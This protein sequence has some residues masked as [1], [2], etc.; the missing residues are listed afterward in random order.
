MKVTILQPKTTVSAKKRVCAYARVSTD[1]AKQGESLENQISYYEKLLKSH[2]DYEFVGVFGD[3]GYTGTK[4]NRPGFQKMIALCRAGKIDIILTKSI[5]RFARNT[6]IVL[7]YVRELKLL[8]VEVQFEKENLKTLS[9]DGELMLT[10]LSSFAEE[11]SRSISENLKWRIKKKFEK[12]EMIIN[13]NR[14]LGYDKDEYGDLII[15]K[16]EGKIIRRIFEDYLRGEGSSK[17]AKALNKEGIPA[18]A[19]GK[20]H[21]T[22]VLHILKNEKY[23]GDALLQKYFRQDHLCKRNTRNNGQRDS[24]YIEENHTPIVSKEMWKQVQE[25]IKHRCKNKKGNGSKHVLSGMLICSKCGAN[26]NRRVWNS[27]RPCQKVI[28]QCG[29][30]VKKGKDI[31]SGTSIAESVLEGLDI[32]EETIVK[33]WMVNGQKHYSYTSKSRE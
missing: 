33:E 17:I 18:V 9:K 8:G 19:G 31:C 4:D 29:N 20:W 1:S 25:E 12:G 28:W 5:S 10:V 16:K 2:P 14:F 30:Y 21:D 15:N 27:G 32:K 23:K 26:L 13:T 22:T 6:T 7:E 24:Y 3:R 11:E